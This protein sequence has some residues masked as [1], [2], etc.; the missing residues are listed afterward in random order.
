MNHWPEC[1]AIW[2]GASFW[3]RRF[4]FVQMKSIGSCMAPTHDLG[5]KLLHSKI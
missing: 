2:N 4:K 1:V 3:A 5:P